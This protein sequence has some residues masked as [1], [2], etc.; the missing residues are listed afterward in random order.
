MSFEIEP[1]PYPTN[2]LAPALSEE[3][4]ELHYG[5]HHRGYLEKL[6]KL[7]DGK[8]EANATLEELIQRARGDLFNNAAQ[9]WNHSFYW[10][11]MKPGGGGEP[12]GELLRELESTFGSFTAFRNALA[13][14]V[15]GEFGSG[16][17]WLT[18]NPMDELRVTSSDDA[19]NPIQRGSAPLLTIDVWEHAYY[20]DYRNERPRYVQA[21]LDRLVNWDFVAENFAAA[22]RQRSGER[23][24]GEGDREADARYREAA[25]EFAASGRAEPAARDA[26]RD[27]GRQ[28]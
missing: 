12:R 6:R 17:A 26:A 23:N 13:E 18:L 15:N 25:R 20:V 28:R 9:V 27:E 7:T 1:L 10:R 24:Q 19:E 16:W 21:F 4:L 2:A 3:T 5:K 14:A 11:C 8:P 22:K